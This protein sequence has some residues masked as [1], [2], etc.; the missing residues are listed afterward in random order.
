M[1]PQNIINDLCFQKRKDEDIINLVLINN[2][3]IFFQS[4]VPA[5]VVAAE[6]Q[7]APVEQ[8]APQKYETPVAAPVV[9]AE[10]APSVDA[11][12]AEPAQSENNIVSAA[13]AQP[14]SIHKEQPVVG[15]PVK[16][17]IVQS[18]PVAKSQGHAHHASATHHNVH[19]P[20]HHHAVH[21][22]KVSSKN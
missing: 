10:A 19:N 6:E 16:E 17:T 13:E 2:G 12:K 14:L 20:H 3:L 22:S 5:P 11:S 4:P 21:H 1:G 18:A 9:V 15:S 7:A 8:A